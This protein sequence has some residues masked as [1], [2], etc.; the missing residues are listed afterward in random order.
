M[1]NSGVQLRTPCFKFTLSVTDFVSLYMH[2]II[3]VCEDGNLRLL[4]I[5]HSNGPF[6]PLVE[7]VTFAKPTSKWRHSQ[8]LRICR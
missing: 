2:V 5:T 4:Q 7:Q 8:R 1:V 3:V 6:E